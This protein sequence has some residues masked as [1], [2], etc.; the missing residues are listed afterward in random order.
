MYLDAVG[1]SSFGKCKPLLVEKGIYISSELG[2][3]NENPFLSM[4]GP[5][6]SGKKVVFPFTVDIK[7]SITTMQQLLSDGKFKPLIDRTYPLERI[8]E[9]FRYVTTGQ[10]IGNGIIDLSN[11][12]EK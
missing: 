3:R 5:L 1:K 8:T 9:A 11:E 4:I 2:P 12:R 10:K 7:G 6:T